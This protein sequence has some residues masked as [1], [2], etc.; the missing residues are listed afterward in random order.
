MPI[1][2]YQTK[3]GVRYRASFK[4]QGIR[5]TQA[6]FAKKQDA[7]NWIADEKRRIKAQT[8]ISGAFSGL[9]EAYLDDKEGLLQH[10]TLRQ[11]AFVFNQFISHH[12]DP[13]LHKITRDHLKT[14]L[15]AQY[16]DRGAK[17][18]NRDLRD[19]SALFSWAIKEGRATLNPAASVN[20]YPE[21]HV[22]RYVP[23]AEDVAAVVMAAN[24]EQMDL[25]QAYLH[26]ACRMGEI[27]SLT[28]DKVDLARNIIWV[29]TRKRKGGEVQWRSISMNPTLREIVTRRMK[30]S[31]SELVFENPRTGG[32][33]RRNQHMIKY[34]LERLCKKAGVKR[35]TIYAFRHFASVK[36]AA[37]HEQG[38]ISLRE[39]QKL[40]GHERLSTTEVYIE[41]LQTETKRIT[42][43]LGEDEN[44][45]NLV[46]GH[47][48]GAHETDT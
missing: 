17:A 44:E 20:S 5:H 27:L 34:M 30:E 32:A 22:P 45:E 18:A 37:A 15:R 24:R 7:K 39:L 36:A 31:Q 47:T 23:P 28:K 4:Y 35:F 9:A 33:Y 40:L 13:P 48:R 38:R 21:H 14:Y 6:G 25:L 1:Y 12:N 43:I 8:P 29:W 10:N 46:K 41:S 11:K 2:K 26:T 16:Q 42:D 3:K 19:L